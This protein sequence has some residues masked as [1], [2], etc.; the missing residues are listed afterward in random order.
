MQATTR[1]RVVGAIAL[2][3]NLVGVAMFAVY[4][5]M[6]PE[7][8]AALPPEQ[9]QV[10]AAVPAWFDAS[11]GTAVV[12]G[13]LGSLALLLHRR[14]AVAAYAV[15]L[16]AVIV[17]M[18]TVYL[19]TP[20]WALAGAKSLPMTVLVIAVAVFLLWYARAAAKAGRLH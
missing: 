3:W 1:D 12:A 17:Q 18:A 9:S 11:Y 15:S 20:A 14:W 16:L 8:L 2:A 13:V 10:Y 19:M 6:T 4:L 7:Q 5:A